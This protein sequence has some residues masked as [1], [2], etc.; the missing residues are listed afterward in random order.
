MIKYLSLSSLFLFVSFHLLSQP[1]ITNFQQYPEEEIGLFE[2]IELRFH[3]Q[4]YS[5]NYDSEVIRVDAEF[6]SPSGKTYVMPGFY[7]NDYVKLKNYNCGLEVPCESLRKAKFQPYNWVVR[8]TP[9]EVGTWSYIVYAQD[10]HGKTKLPENKYFICTPSEKTGFIAKN[11]NRYLKKGDEAIFFTGTNIPAYKSTLSSKIPVDE[12]GT[13]DYKRYID[14]FAQYDANFM[15]VWINTPYSMA[16]VGRELTTGKMHWFDDYNQK[17]A[18]QLDWIFNYAEENGINILLCTFQQN[19]FVNSYGGHYWRDHNAYNSSENS[20]NERVIDSPFDFFTNKKAIKYTKDI[21][22]YIVARWGYAP[23]LIAWKL[24]T[25][26]EQIEKIWSKSKVYAPNNHTENVIKWHDDMADY[27]RQIDPYKHLITTSSPTRTAYKGK[28]FPRLWYNMDL[29][30][31]HDYKSIE[32]I[33]QLK[34]FETHL[35]RIA[36][37][38]MDEPGLADKPYMSQEWGFTSGKTMDKYDPV[39]Y[40]YHC[41]LWSSSMSGAYGSIASWWW[42]NYLV[43]HDLFKELKP[44]SLFMN[45]IV[46][47]LDGTTRGYRAKMNGLTVFYATTEKEDVFIGW[48][49]DD[50]Y[51]FSVV[52]NTKYVY[53]LRTS[54]PRAVRSKNVIIL[55]AKKN[56]L[57]YTVRWYNTQNAAMVHEEIVKSK[58]YKLKFTMPE[59]LR[60]GTFGDGAFII[61]TGTKSTGTK[62]TEENRSDETPSKRIKL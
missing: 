32:S 21:F 47:H 6:R 13:N 12:T 54:K 56:N 44:V 10:K 24:F 49:Q 3:L 58:G 1:E 9:N 16:L 15:K 36:S 50:N 33:K 30:V 5:N 19:S 46:D 35:W 48:C 43:K 18:W 55:P 60:S 4:E 22:R 57:I 61:Q 51:D 31:S 38:F 37:G 42:D 41:C 52:K 23:N 53:D 59:S 25:E 2:K 14:I 7:F 27:I 20:K 11:N 8:F 39:G 45:S 26:V 17:D 29:T 40:E 34:Q 28:E 62:P